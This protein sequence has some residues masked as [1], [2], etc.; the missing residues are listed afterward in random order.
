MLIDNPKSGPSGAWRRRTDLTS[1]GPHRK[2]TWECDHDGLSRSF[3]IDVTVG[4]PLDIVRL[5]GGASLDEMRAY[6]AFLLETA[7]E[8][9][10]PNRKRREVVQCP[11]CATDSDRAVE[12]CVVF[13]VPYS[14]C[15]HC[16]HVFVRSQPLPE[17]LAALFAESEGHAAPYTDRAAL[18]LR[19]AQVVRPKLQWLLRVYEHEYARRPATLID[20]GAGGG[21]FVHVSRQEGLSADGYELNEGSRRFARNMFDIELLGAD[22]LQDAPLPGVDELDVI[23][24]WGLLEYVSEPERFFAAARQ[25]LSPGSGML[26][27]EVPRVD[28]LG[29]AIQ[30]ASPDTVTRHLDPTTHMNL[31]SDASLATALVRSGFRPVAAWYF[32]MDAYELLTNLGR[33]LDERRILDELAGLIPDIQ[34][35]LDAACVCDDIVVAALPTTDDT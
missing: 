5:K 10:G 27:V 3:D 33:Q 13:G 2:E 15:G 32:G 23:T 19:L 22:F 28:C 26:I 34:A 31:F 4:K 18:E 14:R 8:L 24:Y 7:R 20:V 30:R 9:Y 12:E 6:S 21:H 29:S 1:R 25:R 16:G 35:C 17:A 11:C